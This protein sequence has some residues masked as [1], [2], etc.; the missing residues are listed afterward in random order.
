[1]KVAWAVSIACLMCTSYLGG[2]AASE[3]EPDEYIEFWRQFTYPDSSL[4]FP[5]RAAPATIGITSGFGLRRGTVV[6]GVAATNARDRGKPGNADGSFALGFGFG[7]PRDTIGIDLVV[8]STST[9]DPRAGL[10]GLM[11]NE[12]ILAEGSFGFK[13]A[14]EFK[15]DGIDARFSFAV[16]AANLLP[17]GSPEEVGE[18][19]FIVGTALSNLKLLDG[20]TFP[21]NLT[22]GVGSAISALEREPG[23]FGGI[24][25]GVTQRMS[26]SLG[27]LGD[28]WIVGATFY[29]VRSSRM[30]VSIAAGDITQR[31]S[32]GRIL[33]SVGYSWGGVF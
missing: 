19:Y 17:W 13:L 29:P 16:G 18:N 31:T 22:F 25:V 7:D 1:M 10:R 2:A 24:G 20:P 15:I 26:M 6:L 11:G 21:V 3:L 5:N 30:Q 8:S 12:G 32:D 28:E 9:G 23:I 27:W 33:L 4:T 14:R